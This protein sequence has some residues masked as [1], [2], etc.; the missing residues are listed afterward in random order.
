MLSGRVSFKAASKRN[1]HVLG[2]EQRRHQAL[3]LRRLKRDEVLS[4]KRGLGGFNT[5]PFLTCII[6][7]NI[8]LGSKAAI[9]MIRSCHD[10]N[11]VTTSE[12][13]VMHIRWCII[14]RYFCDSNLL[15]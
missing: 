4:Q 14:N 10:D 13:G 7:L 9:D 5:P 6:P 12:G 8:Q 15:K 1:K 2:K 3:Q 11:V